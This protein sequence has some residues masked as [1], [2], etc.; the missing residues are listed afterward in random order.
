MRII[1][2]LTE[3]KE[4][5]KTFVKITARL[6]ISPGDSIAEI[7]TGTK[8][9]ERIKASLLADGGGVNEDGSVWLCK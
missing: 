1:M 3:K 7:N 2:N 4:Q 5:W 8:V 9:F 6:D